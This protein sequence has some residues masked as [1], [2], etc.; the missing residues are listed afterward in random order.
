MKLHKSE[1]PS[2]SSP[3][4]SA[5]VLGA[6]GELSGGVGPLAAEMVLYGL[7]NNDPFVQYLLFEA[8]Q[9]E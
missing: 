4:S 8:K 5:A 6:K 2:S 3:S 7:E 9:Y 1:A